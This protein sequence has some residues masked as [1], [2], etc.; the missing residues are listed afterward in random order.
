MTKQNY[1][2]WLEITKLH[3]TCNLCFLEIIKKKKRRNC[4]VAGVLYVKWID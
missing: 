1:P 3:E 2:R 4:I